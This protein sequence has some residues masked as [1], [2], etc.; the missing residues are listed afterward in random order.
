MDN[1]ALLHI[2]VCALLVR[3]RCYMW[4]Q[5]RGADQDELPFTLILV[6]LCSG[7]MCGRDC[8]ATSMPR[9]YGISA[10]R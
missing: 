5:R 8:S 9:I 2:R 4:S 1:C 10:A 6:Y 7:S 3:G